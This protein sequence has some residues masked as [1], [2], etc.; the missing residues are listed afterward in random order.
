[1]LEVDVPPQYVT[2]RVWR[3]AHRGEAHGQVLGG[4]EA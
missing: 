3:V 4:L 2:T 1:L